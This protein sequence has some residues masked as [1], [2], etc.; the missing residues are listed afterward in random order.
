MKNNFRVIIPQNVDEFLTLSND[1]VNKHTTDGVSSILNGINMTD[2]IAKNTLA[3]TKHD[4]SEQLTLDKEK[5]IEDRDLALGLADT[6]SSYTPN[7]VLY[8]VSGIRDFLLGVN[9][10][11]EKTLGDWGF[12]VNRKKDKDINVLIPRKATELL[13]LAKKIS[14]KDTADGVSSILTPFDMTA[15]NSLLTIADTQ[16]VLA[17]KLKG[18]KEKALQD[19]N[20]AMGRAKTQSSKTKGTLAN[21]VRAVRDVL[22]GIYKGNEQTLSEWGFVV[23]TSL[24]T[25]DPDPTPYTISGIVTSAVGA[26]PIGDAMLTFNTSIG[27]LMTNTN[28]LG[29]YTLDIA[30][31]ADESANVNIM[32]IGFQPFVSIVALTPEGSGVFNFELTP[33]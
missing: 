27:P 32:A 30:N 14:A 28:P 1:I 29:E 19:R 17:E 33:E 15:F 2:M 13:K 21:Y 10:G 20:L 25:P 24:P 12:V 4:E 22:Q 11:S 9:K 31:T 3:K 18:D 7:T 23:N 8:F 6:Q 5:A 16:T 26:T